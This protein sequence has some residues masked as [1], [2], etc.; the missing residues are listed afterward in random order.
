MD[1]NPIKKNLTLKN[2]IMYSTGSL[3]RNTFRNGPEVHKLH[4]EFRIKS[5]ET[6]HKG[7]L[8]K[9]HTDG[10]IT[11]LVKGDASEV[12][13]GVSIHEGGSAYG[14]LVTV[15]MRGYTVIEAVSGIVS[16]GAQTTVP[17][18]DAGV[19]GYAGYV[20]AANSNGYAGAAI[21]DG[22]REDNTIDTQGINAFLPATEVTASG[23]GYIDAIGWNLTPAAQVT[24]LTAVASGQVLSSGIPIL[25]VI[26]D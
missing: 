12:A 26:K 2:E 20:P 18:F 15:A 6:I 16:T 3:T 14:D 17:A 8:V 22:P 11:P 4:L 19:A 5:G 1:K 10:T 24:G 23:E 21:Q 7:Q 9:L 25:V 13:L